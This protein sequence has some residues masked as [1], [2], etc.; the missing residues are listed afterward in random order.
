MR[1]V[2]KLGLIL[3]VITSIAAFVLGITNE[4]TQP[5][6]DQRLHLENVEAIKAL[7]PE[8]EEFELIEDENV[9]N[10]SLIVEAYMG[11]KNGEVVGYTVKTN[12]N[13]YNGRVEV[14]VGITVDGEI[15]GAKIGQHA[16]TPGLGSKIADAAYI[17]QFFNKIVS[18]GFGSTK[19]VPTTD[20]DIQVVTGATVSSDA[21]VDG[22]NAAGALFEE[23][24]VNR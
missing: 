13:G 14:L 21:V 9:T 22:V 23:V 2:I 11:T 5:I 12:P 17:G 10:R 19:D 6:I 3:L 16:E 24:L 4:V 18:V 7:L 20:G 8:A 15:V 1:E